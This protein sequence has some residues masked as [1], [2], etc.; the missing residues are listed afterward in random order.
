MDGRGCVCGV[1]RVG[2][3]FL[4]IGMCWDEKEGARRGWVNAF[5]L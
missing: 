4:L 2:F 5:G 3:F 1:S